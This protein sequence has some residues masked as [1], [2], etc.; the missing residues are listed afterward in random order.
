MGSDAKETSEL[1]YVLGRSLQLSLNPKSETNHVSRRD[2]TSANSGSQVG[3]SEDSD[4]GS[5]SNSSSS[6][7]S[8][9]SSRSSSSSKSITST[10]V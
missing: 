3:E 2:L 8:S 5:S 6:S 10:C 7:S 1:G 4:S 9:I